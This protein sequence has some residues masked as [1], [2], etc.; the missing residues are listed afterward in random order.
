M[1]RKTVK[2]IITLFA[3]ALISLPLMAQMTDEAVYNYV[4]DGLDRGKSQDVLIK[5]LV[6]K[7][8]T[9]EQAMRIQQT[10]QSKG[11]TTGAIRDVGVQ[12]R[13]RRMTGTMTGRETEAMNSIG[14]Q[15]NEMPDSLFK[16]SKVKTIEQDGEIYVLQEK[17]KKDTIIPVFGH[18]IFSNPDLTFE[19]SVNLSTPENYK[20]G[21]GDEVI[22]DIWGANQNT[23]RQTIAPDG[24]I[25]VEGIGLIY[26]TG[27]TVKEADKYMRQQL[28]R[29]YSVEGE[30]AQSDIKLTLGALRTIQVNVMGEVKVPGTYFLSSLSSVYH[31]LYRAGGFTDLGGLRNIELIRDGKKIA[32]VD[33]YDFIVK[34]Q[35]PDDIILQDGDVVLVPTYEM[36]VDIAGKVKRPMKYEMK[37]GETV[38]SILDFAGGFRG[39]AYTPNL[40]IVRR[41]G[42]EYQVYTVE[43]S[44]YASF[45][46]MDTDSLTVGASLDRYENRVEVKGAVYR[47]GAYQLSERINTVG[48]LIDIADGLKGDAFMNR[49]IL[50]R[51]RKDYTLEVIAV[52]LKGI[53][54]GSV[55]DVPL[56]ENDV[57]YVSSIHDLNDLGT[58]TV[59]GEVARP[60]SFVFAENMTVEDAIIQAG[61]LLESASLAKVDVSRRIKDPNS[62]EVADTLAQVF[63]FTIKDGFIMDG[64]EDFKLQKYDQVYVRKSP[65]YNEQNHVTIEGEVLYPGIYA[66]AQKDMR[67]SSIVKDAGGITKWAY[68]KGAK[69]EREM[70]E[71]EIARME[72]TLE[73]MKNSK[74]SLEVKTMNVETTYS[75]GIDLEAALANP[76]GAADV[77]LRDGDKLTIP[78]YINIVKISGNV[79]YPNT[80]TYNP[81]M[82]VKDYVIMAGGYDFKSRRNRAY[83]IY[84]NGTVARARKGSRNVIQPGCEIIVPTRNENDKALE[85]FLSLASTS[86][87][88]AT[89]LATVYNIIK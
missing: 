2:T 61:G 34:G 76:G 27:M 18:N 56:Q 11:V 86:S 60:G 51:E 68:V 80:V 53:L 64:S 58:I 54:N 4:K 83:I 70:S 69:L 35:S 25:N 74:D 78:E 59:N 48:K 63:T 65:I 24:F 72:S 47:P 85:T 21:P 40:N 39:D 62:N 46:L 13:T 17:E 22:I 82:T 37:D 71:E 5:E 1:I 79:M 12:E 42:R 33:V 88:I 84:M 75:I 66:L 6:A 87:S 55:P 28:G 67:L 73:F 49:A 32:D 52:D 38:Q 15:I 3:S 81:N 16:D 20:L 43:S 41:N 50:H 8:V 57:L 44:D 26:L 9:K 19:P 23:I 36:I 89:M 31:A 7:G 29:I 45:K 77:V 30:G 14:G 10:I